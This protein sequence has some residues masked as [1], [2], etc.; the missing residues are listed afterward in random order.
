MS[1]GS[2][3]CEN[4]SFIDNS[5]PRVLTKNDED[6]FD[7]PYGLGLSSLSPIAMLLK[8]CD[9][10]N[11]PWCQFRAVTLSNNSSPDFGF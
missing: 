11:K 2:L 10:A 9:E 7:V 3:L 1:E 8:S 6:T 4:I 5:V